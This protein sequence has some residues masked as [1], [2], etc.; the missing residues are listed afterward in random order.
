MRDKAVRFKSVRNGLWLGL[1]GSMALAGPTLAAKPAAADT[2]GM[3]WT[4]TR[5]DLDITLLPKEGRMRVAGTAWVRLEIESSMGPTLAMNAMK[6]VMR[7]LSVDAPTGAEG[8]VNKAFPLWPMASLAEIR[9]AKPLSR[10]AEVE[11][12]FTYESTT[13]SSQFLVSPQV[14][15]AS[16]TQAWHPMPVERPDKASLRHLVTTVGTTTLHMPPGWHSVS[17]GTLVNHTETQA[18][19]TETWRVS[20]PVARSF[21]AGPYTVVRH[22]VGDRE[23]GVY[24][25]SAKPTSAKAQA[26]AMAGA[27]GAME[28]H[29]GPFPYPSYGIAEVPNDLFTWSAASQQGFIMAS[30]MN[31][32]FEG[33]NLPL[34]AHEAAHAWWGNL[35][36]STGYGSILCTESLAQYSAVLAIEAIEGKEAATEFL[37][38]SRSGYNPAQCARGYFEMWRNRQDKAL[39]QLQ[40]GGWEHNL[41][42]AKGH[43]V[44]HMLRRRVGDDV[45]FATLRGLI[46]EFGGKKQAMS[47]DDLRSAFVAAA[48]RKAKLKRFF[49]QWLDRA[50]API[51]DLEWTP[52]GPSKAKLVVRQAQTGKPY[53]LKLDVAVDSKEGSRLHTI[54]IKGRKTRV[55]LQGNGEPTGVRLDPDHQL[56]IWTPEY[57]QRP[58]STKRDS[59]RGDGR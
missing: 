59:T 48:P 44:Y 47:L 3:G 16:W 1:I 13:R 17:D 25:L 6:K 28:A 14:A 23:V 51:L 29:Y 36:N 34:F 50:G 55:T 12:P 56:L 53:H 33:G 37:R 4:L 10:G 39:S 38:F 49:A 18:G 32:D 2:F 58:K 52:A 19:V 45:F 54:E 20:S 22:P 31:F 40:G 24:L 21:A 30:S 42:D 57:G 43:W 41:S 9:Y 8:V 11:I 35:V 46:Q 26:E 5:L 7:F 27:I 15:V